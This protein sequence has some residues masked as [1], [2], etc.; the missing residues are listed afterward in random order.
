MENFSS[1]ALNAL[2]QQQPLALIF[3]KAEG[4]H[5]CALGFTEVASEVYLQAMRSPTSL[6]ESR[7]YSQKKF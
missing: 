7:A 6:H 5:C 2:P 1:D 4:L 3:R